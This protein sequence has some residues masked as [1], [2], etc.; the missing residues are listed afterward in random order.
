MSFLFEC[1]MVMLSVTFVF[2][3]VSLCNFVYLDLESLFYTVSKKTSTHII[4]Y[5]LR[6]SCPILIIFDITENSLCAVDNALIKT[7]PLV[8]DALSCDL[9]LC[10]EFWCQKLLNSDNY[11]ST[12]SL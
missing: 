11:S 8:H 2:L 1:D 10:E 7:F 12:Y 5:K 4:G 6:N 3:S 9:K